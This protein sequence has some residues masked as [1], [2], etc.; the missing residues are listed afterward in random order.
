MNKRYYITALVIVAILSVIYL[1]RRELNGIPTAS[2]VSAIEGQAESLYKKVN[3]I[4]MHM[5]RFMGAYRQRM[6]GVTQ[7]SEPVVDAYDAMLR[8]RYMY[9]LCSLMVSITQLEELKMRV[10][11]VNFRKFSCRQNV[12]LMK[13][14]LNESNGIINKVEEK[15]N[16]KDN[17]ILQK[18]FRPV[19]ARFQELSSG[20][21]LGVF[22]KFSGSDGDESDVSLPQKYVL[23]NDSSK[24]FCKEIFSYM[25]ESASC[26]KKYKEDITN[27]KYSVWSFGNYNM[28]LLK[29][30]ECEMWASACHLTKQYS[31]RP[32]FDNWNKYALKH[33][34]EGVQAFNTWKRDIDEESAKPNSFFPPQVAQDYTRAF[35]AWR[36]ALVEALASDGLTLPEIAGK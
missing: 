12:E 22:Q 26:M 35:D 18:E 14:M 31:T 13:S 25:M 15:L 23:F 8:V 24:L 2:D 1:A 30:Y 21:P 36:K 7:L 33:L 32:G 3:E 29:V 34:A 11:K 4:G 5:D 27:Y 16:C 10:A 20:W 28:A 9:R 19:A 17:E 6:V